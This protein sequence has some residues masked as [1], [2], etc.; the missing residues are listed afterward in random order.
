MPRSAG[1]VLGGTLVWSMGS[2]CLA[3]DT[4]R[5]GGVGALAWFFGG[6]LVVAIAALVVLV[7]TLHQR[8]TRPSIQK[9]VAMSFVIAGA[10]ASL[11]ITAIYAHWP[12]RLAFLLSRD[13]LNRIVMSGSTSPPARAS[14][15]GVL[16][17]ERTPSFVR[18]LEEPACLGVDT[19]LV[20]ADRG[21]PTDD[22][23]DSYSP[24]G[25][26]WWL[27]EHRQ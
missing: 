3:S 22:E 27:W 4:C 23:V 7:V 17:I 9:A 11:T 25:G 19:G 5:G 15:L 12:F 2:I 6:G 20:Y 14:I 10:V 1:L 16:R 18:L 26:P 8:A 24:L 21:N 13:S